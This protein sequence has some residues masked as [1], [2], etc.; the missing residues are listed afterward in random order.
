MITRPSKTKIKQTTPH[1]LSAPLDQSKTPS[2]KD[3]TALRPRVT[4]RQAITDQELLGHALKGD[5]W[6]SWRILLIAAAG[7]PLDDEER[8]EFTRLTG[9]AREP[10]K[11]VRELICV[12]G[13]RSGKSFAMACF[14]CW[15]IGLCDYPNVAPGETLVA[16]CISRDQRISKIILNY[17]DGILNGSK[18]LKTL[19]T[20]RTQFTIE[21]GKKK[22]IEVR[23]ASYATLRGPSYA[24]IVCDEL[25]T[26]FTSTDFANPDVEI[27]AAVRPGLMT[28]KGPLLMVSS[29]YAKHGVLYDSYKRDFGPD[30]DPEVLVTFGT[31]RDLNPTFSEAEIQREIE[32]DPLRNRA[33]YLSEWRVDL[34]GFIDRN[35]VESCVGDYNELLRVP[36]V[37]YYCFLDPASGV[38]NGDSYVAVISHREG[39][40]VVIDAIRECRAP[41][42]PSVVVDTIII[43]LVKSYGIY[44][45]FGDNYAGEFAKEPIRQAGLQYE[46]WPKHKSDL[47]RDPLLS[48]LNSYQIRLPRNERAVSQICNLE[49]STL[50]SGRDQITHPNHGRDDIANAIAGAA[51]ATYNDASIAFDTNWGNWI[52][53]RDELKQQQQPTGNGN[54]KYPTWAQQQQWAAEDKARKQQEFLESK[55]FGAQQLYRRIMGGF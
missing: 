20:N 36:G 42:S 15:V 37:T 52:N 3:S 35:I 50:R 16:L 46:L 48:L 40:V 28:T 32:R 14:M 6:R 25:S 34:S 12:F 54:Q 10:G 30:G 19:I 24:V 8:V 2:L 51:A 11:M 9:R 21:L 26:W 18:Y 5:L 39:K 44:K 17:I 38:S 13:R 47:Y 55:S 41:F 43:P 23:P 29:A 4:M 45:V 49:C 1:L 31:T 53:G 27:L 33:E 7:E 22:I